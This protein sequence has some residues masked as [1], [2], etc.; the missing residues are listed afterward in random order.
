MS[1]K[2][3]FKFPWKIAE[4]ITQGNRLEQKDGI[5]DEYYEFFLVPLKEKKYS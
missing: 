1:T 4:F 2:T 3:I 5:F